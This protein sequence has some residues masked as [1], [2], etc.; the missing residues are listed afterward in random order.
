MSFTSVVLNEESQSILKKKF[1]IPE[2]WKVICH[3]MTINMGSPNNGPA[4]DLVGQ[5][6]K[7]TVTELAQDQ[8]VMAVRVETDVPSNNAV[9]HITIAVNTAI[10]AKPKQSN[11]LKHW[12]SVPHFDLYGTVDDK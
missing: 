9:K 1:P 8:Y 5:E 10:G 3:H 2:G 7:L 6:F 11:D 4:A 12:K